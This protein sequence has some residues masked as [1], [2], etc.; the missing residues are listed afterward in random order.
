MSKKEVYNKTFQYLIKGSFLVFIIIF[1]LTLAFLVKRIK[2]PKVATTLFD[3]LSNSSIES[4]LFQALE[5]SFISQ[6]EFIDLEEKDTFEENG[7]VCRKISPKEQPLI[8]KYT[9]FPLEMSLYQKG[10]MI[11]FKKKGMEGNANVSWDFVLNRIKLFYIDAGDMYIGK[12]LLFDRL[13]S[14]IILYTN[15]GIYYNIDLAGGL[16]EFKINAGGRC[17]IP[18][19]KRR[20]DFDYSAAMSVN[21]D[22]RV[23]GEVFA[24]EDE[25][26]AFT[27]LSYLPSGL[28]TLSVTFINDIWNPEKGLDRNLF[29]KDIEIYNIVGEVYLKIRKGLEERYLSK[30]YNLSYFSILKEEFKN[31]LVSFFKSRFNIESLKDIV[32]EERNVRTLVKN[33]QIAGL[34]KQT[35]FAPAP[36]KIKT[37]LKVPFGGIKM[38]FTYGIMDEAWNKGGDGVEFKVRLDTK[39]NEPEVILFSKYINP[40]V[41]AED[42][43]WFQGSVDLS[44]FSRKEI[45]LVFETVGSVVSPIKQDFDN[46]YDYAVW[47]D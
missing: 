32:M 23:L 21:I 5:E 43:K 10:E 20:K 39:E 37:K 14:G 27:F 28:H 38:V 22:G 34:T 25:I 15:N 46:S 29:V 3:N 30:D 45:T 24:K 6:E 40:K 19:E 9:N 33:V 17:F 1:C 35:V 4:I 2:E 16:K 18:K 31:D 44:Q 8:D 42:R 47:S 41:N 12:N 36:T 13:D 26:K 7:F 11:S